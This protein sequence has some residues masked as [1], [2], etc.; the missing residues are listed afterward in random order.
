MQQ[1]TIPDARLLLFW[2]FCSDHDRGIS[3]LFSICRS[4]CLVARVASGRFHS[5]V[6]LCP[7]P[8]VSTVESIRSLTAGT[9]AGEAA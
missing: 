7:Q 6:L 4:A 1:L 5:G 3:P 2:Q 9:D 8:R